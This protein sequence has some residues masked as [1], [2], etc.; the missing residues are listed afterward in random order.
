VFVD[1]AEIFCQGGDGG[2]GCV[3]FRREKFVPRGG[4][5]GGDGG[6]GG[7]VVFVADPH[8]LT[9]YDL[10]LRRHFRADRGRHGEGSNRHGRSGKDLISHVPLGT[11]VRESE[12]ILADLSRPGERFVVA[13]GGR[14]GRGNARFA[15]STNRAPRRCEPG[16]KGEE[17]SV[18]LELKLIADAGLVGLPNAGKSTLLR[19]L[20]AAT[21][22]VAPYP[23]TTKQ[24]YLGVLEQGYTRRAILADIPGLI[25]GA[26]KGL[27]LGDRFLRHIE[28]TRILIHLVAVAPEA[29][30]PERLWNDYQAVRH[31]LAAYSETLAAK[32]EIVVINKIDLVESPKAQQKITAFFRKRRVE[33]LLISARDA[34]GLDKLVERLFSCMEMIAATAAGES[35]DSN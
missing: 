16:G 34:K 12:T 33:V 7:D 25:E 27:G 6:D 23:F 32:P 4:P 1:Y 21:P 22:E 14:G 2:N 15:T 3:A 30:A 11:V 29:V 13:K 17:R 35:R 9:L 19:R 31:E 5:A 24:P 20:T 10:Q 8:L 18:S 26:H 28:R